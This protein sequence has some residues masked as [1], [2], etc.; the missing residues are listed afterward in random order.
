VILRRVL[1]LYFGPSS[2]RSM[3]PHLGTN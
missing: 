1:V 2:P 3:L